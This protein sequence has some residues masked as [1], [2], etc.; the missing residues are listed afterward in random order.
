MPY[1][2]AQLTAGKPVNSLNFRIGI[3]FVYKPGIQRVATDRRSGL[4]DYRIF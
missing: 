4:M 3:G 2:T 1:K